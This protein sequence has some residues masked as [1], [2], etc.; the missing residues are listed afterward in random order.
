MDKDRLELIRNIFDEISKLPPEQRDGVLSR[1]CGNDEQLKYEVTSLLKSLEDSDDFLEVALAESAE[2][3][4]NRKDPFI[5]QHIGPYLVEGEAGIGGMGVVYT[6]RRDDN[7]FD[8]K[9]AIK[10]LKHGYISGYLLQRFLR[11]RQTLANLQHPNIARVLDGG[12]TE[13]GL[14]YLVMEFIEGILIT[15]YCDNNHLTI[16]ERLELFRVVCGAVQ[17]AHQHM[18]IHRDIKPGNILVDGEGNPKLLDFGIAKLLDEDIEGEGLT[19]TGAWHLT[20]DYASPEQIKGEQINAASDIYS[21]GILLYQLLTGH[22]AYKITTSSLVAI[23]DTLTG[24]EPKRPSEKIKETEDV[25]SSGGIIKRVT[26][27]EVSKLRNEKVEKLQQR[28]RGDL[29]NIILKATSKDPARRYTSV[30]QFSEDIRRYLVGLPVL[31]RGV[32]IG[33]RLSKFAKRH[34]IGVSF[35]IILTLFLIAGIIGIIWQANIAS[36]ERDKAKIEAQKFE[37]VNMFL[38]EMLSSVDPNELGRDV[39]VYDILEKASQNVETELRDQPEIAADI[40]RTLGNTYTN[41]GQ[42]DDA[43]I[44][45]EKALELNEEIYGRQSKETAKSLHDLG[46]NHHW[47]GDYSLADSLYKASLMINRN[48][49]IEPTQAMA[50]ALNDYALL[51]SENGQYDAA[52]KL[53]REALDINRNINGSK[54][55]NVASVMNN[56]A[57]TLHYKNKLEEAEKYYLE[58]QKLFIDLFGEMHPE[59]G[60]TY[61]NLAFIYMD[62][63]DLNKAEDYFVKSHDLKLKLKGEDHPDVGLALNNLARVHLRMKEYAKAEAEL[64]RAVKQLKKTLPDD[65][66]WLGNS[67]YLFGKLYCETG[68]LRLAENYLRKSL[69]IRGKHLSENH[70]IISQTKSQL[71]HCLTLQKKYEEAERLLDESYASAAEHL[72]ENHKTTLEILSYG[73]D[74]YSAWGKA[75]KANMLSQKLSNPINE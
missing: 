65:H 41:L 75:E 55:R 60:T 53:F 70:L 9:V 14:P 17:F 73:I 66:V 48:V 12:S 56:L 61:N 72:G 59:V 6:G 10:I 27:E 32:T 63:G 31:A 13:D 37:R 18:V 45:L 20:P 23:S 42:Y 51:Q 3:E 64:K 28:L 26:P 43:K 68:K 38:N 69:Q 11:E 34:K 67:Y 19:K 39:K 33:Y 2:K 36:K 21:L 24:I 47:V 54:N 15:E 16:H 40:H 57:I 50:D 74:L 29:D 30:E 44:Q 25:V 71:G 58:A 62:K 22:Q 8:Q 4:R 1:R 35:S 7:T 49:L 52:E 46:L 5:G